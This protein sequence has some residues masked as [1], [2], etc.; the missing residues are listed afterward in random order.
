[1]TT[2][3][4]RI[5][6]HAN[7]ALI[8]PHMHEGITGY[9]EEHRPP[10]SFL[11]AALSNDFLTAALRADEENRAALAGWAMFLYNY[12]PANCWGSPERV[13]EWIYREPPP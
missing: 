8:P 4:V 10:G 11:R 9:V 5:D 6:S 7:W 2:H 1:M 3:E 12:V 13:S